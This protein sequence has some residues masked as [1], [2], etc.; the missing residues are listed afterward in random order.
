MTLMVAE[1][2]AQTVL[3]MSKALVWA[4]SPLVF[5]ME[6]VIV[7]ISPD[8]LPVSA[9]ND[10]FPSRPPLQDAH[11]VQVSTNPAVRTPEPPRRPVVMISP[12]QVPVRPHMLPAIVPEASKDSQPIPMYADAFIATPEPAEL[13]VQV[14]TVLVLVDQ[15]PVA[16]DSHPPRASPALQ[17]AKPILM[18]ADAAVPSPEPATRLVVVVATPQVPVSADSPPVPLVISVQG[19]QAVPVDTNTTEASP[20]PFMSSMKGMVVMVLPPQM[21]VLSDNSPAVTVPSPV[22]SPAVQMSTNAAIFAPEPTRGSVVLVFA[23]HAPI[24]SD[25]PPMAIV[26]PLENAQSVLMMADAPEAAPDPTMTPVKLVSVVILTPETPHP[27]GKNPASTSP[28]VEVARTIQMVPNPAESSPSP[29][30]PFVVMVPTVKVPVGAH[31]APTAL[32]VTVQGPQPIPVY[33]NAPEPAPD[34]LVA[35]VKTVVVCVASHQVPIAS[36]HHPLVAGPALVNAQAVQVPT[37]SAVPAPEPSAWAIVVVFLPHVPIGANAFP[38]PLVVAPQMTPTIK[39]VPNATV[40]APRPTGPSMEAM[41]VV[42]APVEMPVAPNLDPSRSSP[43][44]VRSVSVEVTPDT[45]VLAP[46]PAGSL[47]VVILPPHAPVGPDSTPMPLNIPVNNPETIAVNTNPSV[48]APRSSNLAVEPM[49]VIVAANQVPI[50]SNDDPLRTGPPVLDPLAIQVSCNPTVA[51]PTPS[52]GL[53]E[54][55]AANHVPIRAH[56][57]PVTLIV[58]VQHTESVEMETNSAVPTPSPLVTSMQSMVVV[59]AAPQMP[60]AAHADPARAGPS[61]QCT[62]AV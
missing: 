10:P 46:E 56:A 52:I 58:A 47:V 4:P 12:P 41:V 48:R 2:R 5:A 49:V 18:I 45:S 31:P 28:P 53:V 32:M 21:P 14:M 29:H 61:F 59:I 1:E 17:C 30:G 51:S 6:F 62:M 22:A 9:N 7:M 26:I 44:L 40:A 25:P 16:S 23:P 20:D 36:D 15:V 60:V 42:V 8:K 57:A 24:R 19:A 3:V 37:N 27:A 38:A 34:P 11:P 35:T 54:L 43:A 50:S 55:V 39:V 13:A 33:A